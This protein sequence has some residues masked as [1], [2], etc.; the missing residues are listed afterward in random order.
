MDKNSVPTVSI[1][2]ML[3]TSTPKYQSSNTVYT[4]LPGHYVRY[5]TMG[6]VLSNYMVRGRGNS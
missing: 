2:T 1:R 3:W 5:S 4:I 6:Q